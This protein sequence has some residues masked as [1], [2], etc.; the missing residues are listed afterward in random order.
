MNTMLTGYKTYIFAALGGITV[1]VYLLGYID[2]NTANT[3]M[4]LF[5]FGGIATLRAAL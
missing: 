3:L 5:G 4:A 1:A 2:A